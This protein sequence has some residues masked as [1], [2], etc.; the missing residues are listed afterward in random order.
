MPGNKWFSTLIYTFFAS[1]RESYMYQSCAIQGF[2]FISHILP[3]QRALRPRRSDACA[4]IFN[5][6]SIK[7]FLIKNK[8]Y[9]II[10]THAA[11]HQFFCNSL[12]QTRLPT[13]AYSCYNL[14]YVSI[15]HKRSYSWNVLFSTKQFHK[16]ITSRILY[17]R[18]LNFACYRDIFRVF[19]NYC[20]VNS[21]F[22]SRVFFSALNDLQSHWCLNIPYRHWR[23][24]RTL[25]QLFAW[26]F[27]QHPKS[28]G[29]VLG[30]LILQ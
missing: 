10:F 30:D 3:A 23:Y 6:K 25:M 18:R 12:Q 5:V 24:W 7:H 9:D 27:L 28:T 20:I 17:E 21:V 11:F 22:L 15:I 16:K 14:D 19:W 29:T 26:W 4:R 13:A 2:L 1:Y 8:I